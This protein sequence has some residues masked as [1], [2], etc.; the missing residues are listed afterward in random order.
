M[1]FDHISLRD[2]LGA[3]HPDG[4]S[5]G[6]FVFFRGYMDESYDGQR[7]VFCLSCLIG[8]GNQ[9]I[10]LA[11]D[12]RDC[13][14]AVN[15]KLIAQGRRP[16]SRYHAAD[17]S[18]RAGDFAGWDDTEAGNFVLALFSLLDGSHLHPVSI[19]V[20]WEAFRELFPKN[21]RERSVY[22]FLMTP[23]MHK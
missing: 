23:F 11:R 15:D 8:E 17:C 5:R 18:K 12:W 10:R 13:L 1:G 19:S 9:W 21:I 6:V 16:L 20:D 22:R 3:F 4:A 7:K 14:N 2:L